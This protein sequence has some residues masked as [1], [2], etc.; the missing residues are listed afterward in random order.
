MIKVL[1]VD[2]EEPFRRLL[3]KELTRKGFSV[4]VAHDG[5]SALSLVGQDSFDVVLLD[6]VMPGTDGI[7]VMKN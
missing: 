2:D 4:E 5:D 3:K 6:I 7:T 1:V